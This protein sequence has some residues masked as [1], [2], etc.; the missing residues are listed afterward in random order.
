MVLFEVLDNGF[1]KLVAAHAQRLIHYNAGKSDDSDLCRASANVDYHVSHRVGYAQSDAD[2]CGH[3]F[4]DQFDLFGAGIQGGVAHGT[5]F[6]FRDTA[7]HT[8]HHAADT[9]HPAGMHTLD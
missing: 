2:G 5:F 3:G 1:V 9:G 4:V 6:H 7:W 8:D